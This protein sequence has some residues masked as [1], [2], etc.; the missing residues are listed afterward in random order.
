[1][2]KFGIICVIL[3]CIFTIGAGRV[4]WQHKINKTAAEAKG[5]L[6]DSKQISSN[7]TYTHNSSKKSIKSLTSHL[8]KV[9]KEKIN[10]F[11]DGDK[12]IQIVITGD[13]SILKVGERLQSLLDEAYGKEVFEV[14]ALNFHNENSHD[15]YHND[16]AEK[17]IKQR[18][19]AVIYTPPVIEDDEQVTT[20]DTEDIMM[21]MK[22][23]IEKALPKTAYMT[24]PPNR[25]TSK[26]YIN[27]RLKEIKAYAN[28]NDL[29]YLNYLKRWPQSNHKLDN[30]LDASGLKPNHKGLDMWAD[31]LGD[32]FTGQKL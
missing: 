22:Q 12:P 25:V 27:D 10:K 30:L 19:D 7:R 26:P 11:H 8:P 13:K 28:K 4:Y 29:T 9:L 31:Y 23:D 21:F 5:S 2:K 32:Y 17:I 18:P 6:S 15:I 3:I 20:S 14:S 1:M 16:G 24:E